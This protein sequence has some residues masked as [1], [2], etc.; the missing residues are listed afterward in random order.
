MP[1]DASHCSSLD[2]WT[3]AAAELPDHDKK[4]LNFDRSDELNLLVELH[5]AVEKSRQKSIESAWKYTR[6]SG[7]TVIIRDVFGKIIRWIDTFKQI[8]DVAVQYDPV[9]AS[10]PWAGIRLVLQ[11]CSLALPEEEVADVCADCG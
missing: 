10:L 3:R 7:E 1:T 5:E 2:L 4:N 8:G 9:H 6:K 11:V